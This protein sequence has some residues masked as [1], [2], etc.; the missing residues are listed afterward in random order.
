MKQLYHV[1]NALAPAVN[2][3]AGTVETVPINL[4]NWDHASFILQC[5]A[6]ATGTAQI[7]VEAFSD[8]TATSTQS[9]P[10]YYQECVASD[11]FGPI[12]HAPA[13]GFTTAAAADKVYKIEVDADALHDSGFDYNYVRV[14]S[15]EK[16]AD[17]V[18]G[19]IVAIL[20]GGRFSAEVPPVSALV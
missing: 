14:K 2:A 4:A 5:G 8:A 10:F 12:Q 11:T 7:T 16:V 1:V 6:G 17:P 15:T 20:T 18:A 19:G 3:F 13:G 9:I